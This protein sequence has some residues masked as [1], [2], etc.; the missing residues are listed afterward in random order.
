MT[1]GVSKRPDEAPAVVALDGGVHPLGL[2]GNIVPRPFTFHPDDPACLSRDDAGSLVF[3]T[4]APAEV[5]K[6]FVAID[7]GIVGGV[8]R[9]DGHRMRLVGAAGS[10]T[11]WQATIDIAE[12][13]VAFTLAFE[14]ANGTVAYWGSTG[15]TTGIERLERFAI[16]IAQVPHHDVPEWAKGMVLYQ[17]F[18][19]RFCSG[20]DSLTPPGAEPWHAS[21]SRTGFK[22]GDLIGIRQQ[23]DYLVDLGVDALYLTP[24]FTSPSNHKYDTSDHYAVDPGFGGTE[25]LDALIA[26]A[27]RLGIRILLDVSLNH[28]HPTYAPFADIVANGPESRY[29]GWFVV[30]DYPVRVKVRPPKL[31]TVQSLFWTEQIPR[32]EA[33]TD[34][35]I[36]EATDP[37]PAVDPT[38]EAWFGVPTMPRIDL[39]HPEARQAMIDVA[40]HWIAEHDIDGWRMDVVRYIDADF[41]IDLRR[42]VR[43]VRS[44][45]YLLAEVMGD[46]QQWLDG[47]MF[48]ATMN[49]TFRQLCLDYFA[50]DLIDTGQM[51]EGLLRLL[52]MYSPAVTSVNHNLIGSHD[53]VRFLTLAGGDTDRL[54]LATALQLTFPGAPGLYYGDEVAMEGA[55]DPDNRR[56]FAWD[57]VGSR[58]NA[59]VRA[60]LQARKQRLELRTGEFRLVSAERLVFERRLADAVSLVVINHGADPVSVPSGEVVWAWG[61]TSPSEERLVVGPGAA[62]VVAVA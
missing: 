14:L 19:E 48:D 20:D 43:Q 5:T 3:R 1:D 55:A 2:E 31:A 22:G 12:P 54:M 25:A 58:H 57:R 45:A 56:G 60:L 53:T 59:G 30:N 44:D 42:Q 47:E 62:V 11:L 37:G 24:V 7:R 15:L 46:A 9:V 4:L 35:L 8:H 10:V 28:A 16:E 34:L 49:Y 40:T 32:I 39:Q 52:A 6:A 51:L 61:S 29:A 50:A 41:W 27:H 18:P 21:P 33:E 26:E 36:E 13:H 38:Y 23:L 17:I